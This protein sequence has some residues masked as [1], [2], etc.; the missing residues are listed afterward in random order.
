M[1]GL[2]LLEAA[3]R[4]LGAVLRGIAIFAALA[5]LAL[6]FLNVVGRW[7]AVFNPAWSGEVIEFLV[8]WMVFI[9]AAALWR[10]RAHFQVENPMTTGARPGWR[11][12]RFCLA[13]LSLAFFLVFTFYSTRLVELTTA[14]TPILQLPSWLSYLAMPIAGAIMTG[15]T[16][17]DL[18][19]AA[20]AAHPTPA[21][22]QA[23]IGKD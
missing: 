11:P 16:F 18:I 14:T 2:A 5:I 12:Y 15:Y 22:P 8:A 1:R 10:E 4:A 6:V 20:F 7:F 19:Q 3:D 9:G 13:L 23:T 21:D 17:R